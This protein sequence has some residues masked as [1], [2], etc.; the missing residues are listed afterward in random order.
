MSGFRNRQAG[1]Y[2]PMPLANFS[3]D[4]RVQATCKHGNLIYDFREVGSECLSRLS[5]PKTLEVENSCN[6]RRASASPRS[7]LY[8]R[9]SLFELSPKMPVGIV[10]GN[11]NWE[12]EF[13]IQESVWKPLSGATLIFESKKLR[14]EARNAK[15]NNITR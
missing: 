8:I 14:Q 10:S 13:R 3:K 2:C 6:D 12:A 5:L 7:F 4:C 15:R 9:T 1:P 11:P